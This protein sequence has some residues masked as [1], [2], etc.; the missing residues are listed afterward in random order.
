MAKTKTA[1]AKTNETKQKEIVEKYVD[2][3]LTKGSDPHSVYA[4]VKELGIGEDEFYAHFSSF[5]SLKQSIWL[6]MIN[7]TLEV[8]E[9]DKVYQEYNTRE[10]LLAFYYTLFERMLKNRSYVAYTFRANPKS[11]ESNPAQLKKFRSA[12]ME[13]IQNL[14]NEG[15][16]QDEIVKRPVISDRY[17]DGL[18]VQMLFLI[19]FW[20][21]DDS[22]G[23][24]KT[25]AAIEKSVSL[26]FDLMGNGPLEKMIDFAKFLY[27]NR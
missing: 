8:L 1:K 9:K 26:A 17:K 3:V 2:Y 4:F 21:K 14:L 18:W 6:H 23:F 10:R 22:E 7:D 19:Q 27:Q 12:Y 24:E 16:E 20:L 15:I 11:F 13:Y 5:D 25:D